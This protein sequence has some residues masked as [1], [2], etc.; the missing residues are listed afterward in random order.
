MRVIYLIRGGSRVGKC[1]L[2]INDNVAFLYGVR[3]YKKYRGMGYCKCL[4]QKAISW[5]RS[6]R[7]RQSRITTIR[8][9]VEHR[10][11]S[12]IK[13]YQHNGFVVVRKNYDN[14]KLFGYTMERAI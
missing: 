11:I 12:A 2:D 9:H 3:V 14:R 6:L 8:L 13:C 5:V 4:V 1:A 10:N 7:T